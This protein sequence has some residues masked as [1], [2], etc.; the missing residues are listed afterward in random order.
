[1]DFVGKFA[2]AIDTSHNTCLVIVD[3]FSKY[4]ILEG[5]PESIDAQ[6]TAQIFIKR[7]VSVW[8][9]PAVVISDRG[10]QFSSQLWR[11]V[12]KSL[13]SH[14][15]L[16][17]SHHPQTDGQSE[18]AVQTVL[19]L[20]RSYATEQQDQ[21]EV[22]LPMLE[23]A[24]NDAHCKSTMT[25]PFRLLRG[26]DPVGPQHF[27]VGTDKEGDVF[28]RGSWE[29]R[30]TESQES[31][32]NF[33]RTRQKEIAARMKER[34]DLHRKALDLV[35][36]D[37]VLLSTKSHHLL[38]GFRKQQE[39]FVGPYVVKERCTPTLI[40]SWG[41]HPASP[42]PKTS[43]SSSSF[44]AHPEQFAS[45]PEPDASAP[46]LIQGQ[47]EWEVEEV[48]D[49][50]ATRTGMM[51]LVKWKGFTRKQWLVQEDMENSRELLREYHQKCGLPLTPFLEEDSESDRD[52]PSSAPRD[53]TASN[54]PPDTSPPVREFTPT[55]LA[56]APPSSTL[57]PIPAQTTRPP[58][59]RSPRF[60]PEQPPQRPE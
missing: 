41:Y 59:R 23:Y 5:V 1:M 3:K 24:L 44:T 55:P 28:P 33:V 47:Y 38:E 29:R 60:Q 18:R 11:N 8:G 13:G 42:P 50:R 30:W 48:V 35:P 53:S 52:S 36:G 37:L 49:H 45:R 56:E 54:P 58:L 19:R 22:L 31:V 51:Y 43:A 21:W 9:V 17:T 10:P 32:W 27:M 46:E 2:P 26:Y 40:A 57:S 34:Y 15:A 7:V 20:I 14:A 16:A 12:L 39:R 25:T 6:K 4:T